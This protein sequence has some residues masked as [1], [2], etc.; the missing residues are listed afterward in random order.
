[1]NSYL[2]LFT[3]LIFVPQ[4]VL[5]FKNK[6]YFYLF[7]FLSLIYSGYFALINE[8]SFIQVILFDIFIV[9]PFYSK[10]II[11]YFN[12]R[13][14]YLNTLKE[15]NY[16]F[17]SLLLFIIFVFLLFFRLDENHIFIKIIGLKVWLFYI[18]L[19]FITFLTLNTQKDIIRIFRMFIIIGLISLLIIIFIYAL[20][21]LFGIEKILRM[22]YFNIFYAY[23]GSSQGGSVFYLPGGVTLYRFASTF[24]SAGSLSGFLYIYLFSISFLLVTDNK[25]QKFYLPILVIFLV[26]SFLSGIRSMFLF[27]PL[28][29]LLYS[30]FS[31]NFLIIFYSILGL[32]L[33]NS[34]MVLINIDISS[35][36]LYLFNYV[37]Y[38]Q[39]HY[40]SSLYELITNNFFGNGLGFSTNSARVV[41]LLLNSDIYNVNNSRYNNESYYAK[42]INELGVIGLGLFIVFYM[43]IFLNIIKNF[44]LLKLQRKSISLFFS[45][46]IIIILSSLKGWTIDLY[47]LSFCLWMY[48]GLVLKYLL[49]SYK[50]NNRP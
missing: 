29:F 27:I 41:N 22:F 20:T 42:I 6:N 39:I 5:I 24:A 48:L 4:A 47:P 50:Y 12:K 37:T 11:E 16:I 36:F 21:N 25:N 45:F 34:F 26:A 17:I 15:F 40:G 13:E 7:S 10:F 1:M 32:F 8:I 31:L 49:I 23:T 33:F 19:F 9:L 30:I 3:I 28:F 14:N 43:S 18:P 44:K 38:I 46:I 35:F 2:L